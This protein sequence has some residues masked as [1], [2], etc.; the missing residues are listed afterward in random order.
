MLARFWVA[1][2][3]MR[4]DTAM[5]VVPQPFTLLRPFKQPMCLCCTAA[6]TDASNASGSARSTWAVQSEQSSNIYHE[7]KIAGLC[8]SLAEKSAQNK[9]TG[10]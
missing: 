5:W 9:S 1:S 10:A 7:E 4:I 8:Q 2:G 6:C 3:T